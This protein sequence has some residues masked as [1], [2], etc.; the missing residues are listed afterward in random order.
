MEADEFT[1]PKCG[2]VTPT[3]IYYSCPLQADCPTCGIRLTGKTGI[4]ILSGKEAR[5]KRLEFYKSELWKLCQKFIED[6]NI[7]C[8]ETIHQCDWVSLNSYEFIEEICKLVGYKG[9]E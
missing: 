3:T 2:V 9:E 4:K 5:E 8:K 7:T 6:N 1:C